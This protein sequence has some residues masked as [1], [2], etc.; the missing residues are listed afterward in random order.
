MS[1][2]FYFSINLNFNTFRQ[3]IDAFIKSQASFAACKQPNLPV[4]S[5][6]M[7]KFVKEVPKIDCSSA[8]EDWV[9]C[10]GS[11]CQIQDIARVKYGPLKC[12][13]TDINRID[14]FWN[15]DGKAVRASKYE[16]KASD[17]VSILNTF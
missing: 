12:S 13:F 1:A 17:V 8:G 5:P 11:Q 16:L 10:K 7:M 2:P 3:N 14:D 4:D 15:R 9:K 6:E